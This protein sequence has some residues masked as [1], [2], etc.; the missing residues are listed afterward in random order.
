MAENTVKVDIS[1][2]SL[3]EAIS[4]LEINEKHKLWEFLEAE[5]FP[6]DEDSPEDIAEIQAAHADYEAGDYTTF[7]QYVAQRAN[8]SA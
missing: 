6:D 2:Q 5:L 3:L 4:S 8:R 1:F 7:D